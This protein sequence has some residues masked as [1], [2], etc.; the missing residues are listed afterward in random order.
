MVTLWIHCLSRFQ[1]GKFPCN[2]SFLMGTREMTDFQYVK[3]FFFEVR[4]KMMT[5][6]PHYMSELKWEIFNQFLIV[7]LT[8]VSHLLKIFE[9]VS[10]FSGIDLRSFSLWNFLLSLRMGWQTI[11]LYSTMCF[12]FALKQNIKRYKNIILSL[13]FLGNCQEIIFFNKLVIKHYLRQLKNKWHK[14][15]VVSFCCHM[16]TK[17]D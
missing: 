4:E 6:K 11:H 5:S 8:K 9:V 13:S 14:I 12:Y 10:R 3:L 1:G 17:A 2:N 15:A 7:L 16:L